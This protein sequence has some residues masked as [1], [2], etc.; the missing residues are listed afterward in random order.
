MVWS[1]QEEYQP[2]KLHD[3]IIKLL[4]ARSGLCSSESI[5][6]S[7]RTPTVDR[8]RWCFANEIPGQDVRITTERGGGIGCDLTFVSEHV[9]VITNFQDDE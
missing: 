3:L 7:K 5:R 4:M 2:R 9:R 8:R 6:T 1:T